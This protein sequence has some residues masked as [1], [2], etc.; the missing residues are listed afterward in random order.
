[1]FLPPDCQ[2]SVDYDGGCWTEKEVGFAEDKRFSGDEWTLDSCP[3][4]FTG[5]IKALWY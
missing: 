1:M 4:A 3:R 2:D 5:P